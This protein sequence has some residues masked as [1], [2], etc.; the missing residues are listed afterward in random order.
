[1]NNEIWIEFNGKL[2]DY[3]YETHT[4]KGFIENV[5][6]KAKCDEAFLVE[7]SDGSRETFG[8]TNHNGGQCNCCRIYDSLVVVR[9]RKML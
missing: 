2:G 6:N 1:M 4:E 7:F 8:S 3:D 5:L 9:Y